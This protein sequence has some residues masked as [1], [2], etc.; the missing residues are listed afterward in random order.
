MAVSTVAPQQKPRWAD[1]VDSS[2]ET[3]QEEP[4]QAPLLH[5]DS[6]EL[7]QPCSQL[8]QGQELANHLTSSVKLTD[9]VQPQA[10]PLRG[11]ARP[12]RSSQPFQR[13]RHFTNEAVAKAM[14]QDEV[15]DSPRDWRIELN[16][17]HTRNRP[18][19]YWQGAQVSAQKRPR[20]VGIQTQAE[21]S[22]TRRRAQAAEV[23]NEDWDWP[24]GALNDEE[25]QRR[26]SKRAH[27]I[28]DIKQREEYKEMAR[29]REQG[30]LSTILT[31]KASDRTMSKRRWEGEVQRWRQSLREWF[32]CHQAEQSPAV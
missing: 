23:R 27:A 6:Y 9:E 5:A 12:L 22:H 3:Q 19:R 1:I 17:R 29:M 7:S 24:E 8:S 16:D 13:A 18:K 15:P 11:P 20:A 32:Q 21:L 25:W 4:T 31:P 2:Q 30:Q 14:E 28:Q 10:S 26:H